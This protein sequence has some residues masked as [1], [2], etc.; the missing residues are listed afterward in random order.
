MANGTPNN[1]K[2]KIGEMLT[3][4]VA[5]LAIVAA[6]GGW[7][8]NRS[9]SITGDAL[10]NDQVQRNTHELESHDLD[11]IE[12]KLDEIKIDVKEIKELLTK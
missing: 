12:Y 9:A 10:L 11:V 5:I 3:R 8:S 4:I 2:I 6:I 7:A 1:G